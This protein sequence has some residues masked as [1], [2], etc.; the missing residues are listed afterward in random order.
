ML[1]VTEAVS[2]VSIAQ[3]N[4]TDNFLN[5]SDG[6]LNDMD[7]I[8]NVSETILNICRCNIEYQSDYFLC[9][10]NVFALILNVSLLSYCELKISK[11]AL[12]DMNLQWL[13]SICF[14]SGCTDVSDALLYF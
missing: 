10:Q 5:I 14:F 6:I 9:L 12:R 11:A 7:A 4:F 3:L 2:N 8:L 13:Y 1:N